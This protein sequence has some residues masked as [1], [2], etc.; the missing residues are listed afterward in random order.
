M[1]SK[2]NEKLLIVEDDSMLNDVLVQ[3]LEMEGYECHSAGCADDA[4]LV[5][6]Q[7]HISLMISDIMMPG[8]SGIELLSI[9]K[10]KYPDTA[11]IMVTALNDRKTA[12]KALE[13]GAYGYV[14]KPF[15]LNE[16]IIS[17]VNSLERRRLLIQSREYET[18]LEREVLERTQD[19]R[20]REEEI[21]LRLTTAS[22]YRDE[23]TGS[24]IRR[25]G[26]YCEVMA[27][28][29]SW[30]LKAVKDIRIAAPMH[31]IG[32]IGI[33]DSILLKPKTLTP[34]EF[35]IIKNHTVIGAQI[36][37]GSSVEMLQMAQQIALYHHEKWDGTGYPYGIKGSDI[38]EPARL[39]AVVDVY[40]A[41]VHERVYRPP[42]AENE[43]LEI[44]A[45]DRGFHFNPDVFDAFI[46]VLPKLRD[47]RL[48]VK[49]EEKEVI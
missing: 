30:P 42:I 20:S 43:A 2:G 31:D 37:E 34:E 18:R 9:V 6:E 27:K 32:K 45:K 22:D 16:I 17:V 15:D 1:N 14:L 40:D 35:Q 3:C 23:E 48:M 39:I 41:L 5:L 36:L 25:L 47:I 8:R 49:E 12:L 44:M 38:P 19:L 33:P 24:H 11:V 4:L 46:R 21:C 10:N 7:V 28:E 13:L 26:L 29:M